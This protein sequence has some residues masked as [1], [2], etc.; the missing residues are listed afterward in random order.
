[1]SSRD[2]HDVEAVDHL[3]LEARGVGQRRIA[4]RRADVGEQREVLAQA[5]QARFRPHVIGHLVPLRPAD[6]AEDHGVAGHRLRHGGVVDRLAVG[7][8]GAA[9]DQPLL[10][11]ERAHAMGVHPC[12]Q[13]FHL[14][15]DFGADA[16]AGEQ[17]ELVGGHDAEP[18]G[19]AQNGG[20]LLKGWARDWQG[21]A[22]PLVG[23]LPHRANLNGAVQSQ[24]G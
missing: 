13:P 6:R 9:A 11:F 14:G 23:A 3:A 5:Q 8:V 7:V 20:G 12:D 1:M 24:F 2:D 21:A 17:E 22:D 15:H 18:R 19:C 16:V 10:V 4:D